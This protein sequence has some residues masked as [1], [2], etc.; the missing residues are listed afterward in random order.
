MCDGLIL[1]TPTG[2]TGHS[3][4]AGGPV[5]HPETKGLIITLI[6]PHTLSARPLVIPD[7]KEIA[8]HITESPADLLLTIDGQVAQTVKQ[9][10]LILVKRSGEYAHFIH[11]PGFNYFS[12]LRQKLHW[13]GSTMEN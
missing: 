10:E 2:S 5:L 4:S 6:C 1:S 12:L 11:M 8:I 13:H 9:T 3:L 7:D